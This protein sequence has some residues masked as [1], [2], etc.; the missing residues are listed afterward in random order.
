[1]IF[2]IENIKNIIKYQQALGAS[3]ASTT[4]AMLKWLTTSPVGIILLI[5]TAIF[6]VTKPF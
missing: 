3:I 1:M 6:S 4:K 2:N 5:G